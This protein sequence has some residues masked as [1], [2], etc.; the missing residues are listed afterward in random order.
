M[1][2]NLAELLSHVPDEIFYNDQG[3]PNFNAIFVEV[4]RAIYRETT[5]EFSI[6]AGDVLNGK[7]PNLTSFQ[8]SVTQERTRRES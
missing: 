6:P 3:N 1:D 4:A 2:H 5:D 8:R 7:L